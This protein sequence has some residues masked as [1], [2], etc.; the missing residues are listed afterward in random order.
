MKQESPTIPNFGNTCY[1]NTIIQL[2]YP[3][4]M[5]IVNYLPSL[6]RI[7]LLERLDLFEKLM[8]KIIL[9]D[10]LSM[11]RHSSLD[12]LTNL[13]CKVKS[14]RTNGYFL[15]PDH[16]MQMQRIQLVQLNLLLRLIDKTLI[17]L[18]L[19]IF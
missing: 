9:E 5:H 3:W 12:R 8:L 4:N 1:L 6:K 15:R 7:Q 2:L 17:V 19:L 11:Q 14:K 18:K 10:M 16:H 13:R